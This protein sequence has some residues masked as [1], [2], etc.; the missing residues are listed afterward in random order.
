MSDSFPE[1][2]Q[3][4]QRQLELVEPSVFPTGAVLYPCSAR[5][6]DGANY[7]CVYFVDLATFRQLFRG[8]EP[9]SIENLFWIPGEQVELIQE[10]PARLPAKF[11][12]RIYQAP[13]HWGYHSFTLVFSWWC[14]RDYLVGGF[15]DFL[16]Y[17]FRRG[18]SDVKDIL[19][20]RVNKRVTAV[21]QTYW[22]V[23]SR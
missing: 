3:A 15:V 13:G 11:A 18:P 23:F 22:C 7:A 2:G 4:S 20:C 17:S 9:A 14:R 10:S 8:L 5:L 21:P 19:L 1:L 6:K 12:N 16:T